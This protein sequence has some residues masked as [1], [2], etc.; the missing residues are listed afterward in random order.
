MSINATLKETAPCRK[1]LRV[2]V[3]SET[4]HAEF[5]EVYRELKRVAHV[6]GFR[7]GSAPRDLLKRYHGTKAR[8][9][10]REQA[11]KTWITERPES[12]N[13]RSEIGHWEGDT[14]RG[15]EKT[16]GIAEHTGFD[17]EDVGNGGGYGFHR[18]IKT[19]GS[20]RWRSASKR[21][22]YWP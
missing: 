1:Q 11:K 10:R 18:G 9:F 20:R 7:V 2:E 4:V 12:I 5:E 13:G 17:D 6:P 22:R 19:Q 16:T 3:P 15:K 21:S 8:E 14:I